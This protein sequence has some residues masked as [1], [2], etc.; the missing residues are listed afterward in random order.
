MRSSSVVTYL[1][2]RGNYVVSTASGPELSD[3]VLSSSTTT[4]NSLSARLAVRFSHY[5][6]F[7]LHFSYS[8]LNTTA[9]VIQQTLFVRFIDKHDYLVHKSTVRIQETVSVQIRTN[10][11]CIVVALVFNHALFFL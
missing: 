7:Y 4:T 5:V 11:L 2:S 9:T 1:V 8:C 10:K 6:Y 3:S